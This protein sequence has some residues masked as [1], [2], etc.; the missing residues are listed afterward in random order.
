MLGI[1]RVVINHFDWWVYSWLCIISAI[2]DFINALI[3]ILSFGYLTIDWSI[4]WFWSLEMRR[5]EKN[6]GVKI[7]HSW[8]FH[9]IRRSKEK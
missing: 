7:D 8:I 5:L 3:G 6:R 4:D 9:Y 1:K 2:I